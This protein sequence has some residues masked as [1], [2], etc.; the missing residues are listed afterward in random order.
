MADL[1][2][3][4][5]QK[6]RTSTATPIKPLSRGDLS[7]DAFLASQKPQTPLLD[8]IGQCTF[9]CRVTTDDI[10]NSL[11]YYNSL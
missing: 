9:N 11:T 6:S 1:S 10:L 2:Y 4:T 5:F 8:K 7:Y 3:E